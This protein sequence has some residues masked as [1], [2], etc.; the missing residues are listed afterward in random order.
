MNPTRRDFIRYVGILL[1]GALARSCGTGSP[2]PTDTPIITCYEPVP[3]TPSPSPPTT[4]QVTCYTAVPLTPT[5]APLSDNP[6]WG[7]LRGYWVTMAN[8]EK[9]PSGWTPDAPNWPPKMAEPH[10]KVIDALVEAGELDLAVAEQ[11]QLSFEAA[12]GHAYMREM[13]CYRMTVEGIRAQETRTDFALQLSL[14]DEMAAK[15][16]I[17]PIVVANAR[18]AL[19]R[20]I[21]WLD[22]LQMGKL[23]AP[24][25][26]I[27]ADPE[28]IE[29]TRILVELLLG[30]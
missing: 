2:K 8:L 15:S 29:A 30:S 18:G 21:T 26:E 13:R 20:D 6:L 19:E 27:Q 14:L 28:A 4:V 24:L 1:A 7:E 3:P 9:P 22:E 5:P 12:A 16:D 11:I 17:D 23:P 25:E 10:Q